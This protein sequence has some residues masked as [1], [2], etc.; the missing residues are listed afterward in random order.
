MFVAFRNRNKKGCIPK[1]RK[2]RHCE[3]ELNLFR[4]TNICKDCHTKQ[5]AKTDVYRMQAAF[6]N[7]YQEG[8]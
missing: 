5:Y 2:C 4:K 3:T 1:I 8:L 7:D 6:G